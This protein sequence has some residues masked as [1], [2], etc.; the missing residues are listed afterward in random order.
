[1]LFPT[2]LLVPR[3]SEGVSHLS[4]IHEGHEGREEYGRNDWAELWSE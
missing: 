2:G 4:P 1:M 3:P